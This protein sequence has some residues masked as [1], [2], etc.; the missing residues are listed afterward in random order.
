MAGRAGFMK[1]KTPYDYQ[2]LVRMY[3]TPWADLI[4]ARRNGMPS[5]PPGDVFRRG[6]KTCAGYGRP[7]WV[8]LCRTEWGNCPECNKE[9]MDQTGREVWELYGDR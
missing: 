3:G 4:Y 1:K 6:C 8:V 5:D 7:G 2:T 9:G